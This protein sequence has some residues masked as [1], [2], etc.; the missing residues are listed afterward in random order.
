M[1]EIPRLLFLLI[2]IGG[3]FFGLFLFLKGFFPIKSAIPGRAT[4]YNIPTEPLYENG[5]AEIL[6]PIPQSADKPPMGSGKMPIKPVYGRLVIMLIDALRADFVLGD[7]YRKDMPYLRNLIANKETLSFMAKAHP[8]TVTMP[9]IKG[10]TTGTIPGFIDVVLNLNSNELLDDNLISQMHMHGKTILFYG[11]DTWMRLFPRQFAEADGT[12]S[13]FVTDYTEVDNNVTRHINV[14]LENPKWDMLLLHYLGLDHIGHIGGPKSSL[15]P[16]KLREMDT[17]IKRIHQRLLVKD[18]DRNQPTLFVLCGDHGMSETGSHGGASHQEIET[19]LVFL[20]SAFK[21]K[22]GSEPQAE[23]IEQIDLVPTLSLLLGLPIPQNSLGRGIT[24]VLK[25]SFSLREQMRAL[26]LN[27][28][29]LAMVLQENVEAPGT[30]Q[31]L[32]HY[33]HA[34]RLHHS[35]LHHTSDTTS[36]INTDQVAGKA[37][38]LYLKA[39]AGMKERIASS[40][41]RY[42]VHAMGC[43]IIIIWQ[44]LLMLLI[45]T[46]TW[47]SHTHTIRGSLPSSLLI[48]PDCH[49]MSLVVGCCVFTMVIQVMVCTTAYGE[50]SELLCIGSWRAMVISQVFVFLCGSF[51]ALLSSCILDS[52]LKNV[53]FVMEGWTNLDKLLVLG[54]IIHTL[55]LLA[56]SF[57]E[58]EHQTW[59]FLTLTLFMTFALMAVVSVEPINRKVKIIVTV[60]AVCSLCR[61]LRAWN[62]TGIKWV[63]EPD[64]G[65]WLVR[66]E[67]RLY[68]SL[69]MLSSF[70]VI[71]SI[72]LLHK[73]SLFMRIALLLHLGGVYWYRF[74]T[75]AVSLPFSLPSSQKGIYEAR[76]I[77]L[78]ILIVMGRTI[79]NHVT[80]LYR[81]YQ[82]TLSAKGPF[83]HSEHDFTKAERTA[84]LQDHT[85][86]QYILGIMLMT[87]LFR[88]HN[89]ALAAMLVLLQYCIVGILLPWLQLKVW[90]VTLLHIWMA[91]V[92]FS[93]QG[94][95]ISL[96]T[97]DISAGYI[98]LE[99]YNAIIAGGLTFLATY[100]GY[101]LWILRLM[102]YITQHYSDRYISA[103]WE[104]CYTLALS[105]ALPI[106]VYT[107]LVTIERYHLFVWSVFSPKLLYEASDTYLSII[108]TLGILCHLF[109]LHI[110]GYKETLKTL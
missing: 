4:F 82:K 47:A 107:I 63:N 54:T 6:Q 106:A 13:F 87:L 65:D 94:N 109:M 84:L 35:W 11:D 45:G 15:V 17:I 64:I 75:G 76:L 30:E 66:P 70:C 44:V 92:A 51:G 69:I 110:C 96:A 93:S 10:L 55:S 22:Q 105:R 62:Q 16:P 56:S 73:Q 97:I 34:V 58:E 81:K 102:V 12:T 59:Y 67:N 77:Y 38:D 108:L 3:Q 41:T 71:Y 88:P 23:P 61:G 103:I 1:V 19:P 99:S 91:E 95:S 5:T 33:Q 29:Q 90:A 37:I 72:S 57:V 83:H 53:L 104:S 43:G 18:Q 20:S 24:S 40:L 85:M 25:H 79:Y 68:L 36:T 32:H 9:R 14:A 28:H 60:V 39:M 2:C 100:S 74:S 80:I 50:S 27:C 21:T 46:P 101:L 98:G 31:G 7:A 78:L 8:P 42:D 26:Q 86:D 89:S 48:G 52:R 49:L